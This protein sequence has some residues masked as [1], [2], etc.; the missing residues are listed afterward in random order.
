M[1]FSLLYYL[2]SLCRNQLSAPT[3]WT[4]VNTY[5]LVYKLLLF[6]AHFVYFLFCKCLFIDYLLQFLN[7]E[8]VFFLNYLCSQWQINL[9]LFWILLVFEFEL[10]ILMINTST[11]RDR[12]KLNC[13]TNTFF[14]ANWSN[15]PKQDKEKNS[16]FTLNK[17]NK[18]L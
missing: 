9:I 6:F 7:Q 17:I 5:A 8:I 18:I 13:C 11:S 12:T 3:H 4:L 15:G 2:V 10:V 14:F 1:G 16:M